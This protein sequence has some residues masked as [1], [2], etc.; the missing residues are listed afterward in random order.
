M[1]SYIPIEVGTFMLSR[2]LV[3]AFVSCSLVPVFAQSTASL[4]GYVTDPSDASIPGASVTLKNSERGSPRRLTTDTAGLYIAGAL[5]TG[6]YDLEVRA[7]GF[8][9]ARQTGIV[10]TIG[11]QESL[12][13][14]LIV[15]SEERTVTVSADAAHVETET[16]QI[17]YL[18]SNKEIENI[19]VN[20]RNFISLAALVSGAASNLADEPC[21]GHLGPA[22]IAYNGKPSH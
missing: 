9:I 20:G 12:N 5:P 17:G 3:V 22:D 4:S 19:A 6:A 1:V 13:F 14:K 18:V 15:G 11:A 2:H 10:L 21:V 8:A 7:S 16:G